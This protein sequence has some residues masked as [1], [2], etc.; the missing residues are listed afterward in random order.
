MLVAM[1]T[2]IANANHVFDGHVHWMYYCY[3]SAILLVFLA[4]ALVVAPAPAS[5]P[6][7]VATHWGQATTKTAVDPSGE[8]IAEWGLG[9]AN[10]GDPAY[11]VGVYGGSGVKF[12]DFRLHLSNR[13]ARFT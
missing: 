7:V 2:A 13:I 4:V 11:E 9:I 8:L 1:G 6:H 5:R 3:G 12:G 10:D